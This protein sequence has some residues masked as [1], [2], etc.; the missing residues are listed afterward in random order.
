MKHVGSG[1]YCYA[2]SLAMIFGKRAPKT[3]A[4]EVLTGVPFGAL[5]HC[6]FESPLPEICDKRSKGLR[7]K[8]HLHS[9]KRNVR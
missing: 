8:T 9:P 3:S 5:L 7:I 6:P 1:P 2:N 4:I